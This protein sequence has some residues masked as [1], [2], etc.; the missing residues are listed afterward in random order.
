MNFEKLGAESLLVL[1]MPSLTA[2]AADIA[3]HYRPPETGRHSDLGD[4]ESISKFLHAVAEG[5]YIE[6]AAAIADL[7]K[8]TVY[9]WLKQAETEPDRNNAQVRFRD[10]V[11]KARAMSEAQDVANVRKAGKL[12]QFWAASMTYL[13]RR[14]PEKWGKRPETEAGPRVMVFLGTSPEHVIQI[15]NTRQDPVNIIDSYQTQTQSEGIQIQPLTDTVS[16]GSG[17]KV[18][19]ESDTSTGKCSQ[20]AQGE[21][22]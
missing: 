20:N 13:E 22:P 17:A 7:S 1:Y 2:Q 21:N 14:Y 15:T 12:P 5:N 9:R 6:T 3:E 18:P 8:A 16:D 4:A 11:E 10:A 19:G